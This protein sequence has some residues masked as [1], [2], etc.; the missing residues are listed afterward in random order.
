MQKRGRYL[1]FF[2][3]THTKPKKDS[4]SVYPRAADNKKEMES[5]E[6]SGGGKV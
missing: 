5:R 2:R 1:A 3:H 6:G 4:L